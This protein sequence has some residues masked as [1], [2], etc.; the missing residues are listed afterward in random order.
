MD[1]VEIGKLTL[2][3]SASRRHG[4]YVRGTTKNQQKIML[5]IIIGQQP[6]AYPMHR[7]MIYQFMQLKQ[8]QET[9][10]QQLLH[11]VRK[12]MRMM[13]KSCRLFVIAMLKLV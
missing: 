10:V 5:K 9:V 11:L 8:I 12:I 4:D 7:L 1:K 6:L 2:L 3:A 13:A